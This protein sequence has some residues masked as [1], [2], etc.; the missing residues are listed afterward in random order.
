MDYIKLLREMCRQD[1]TFNEFLKTCEKDTYLDFRRAYDSYFTFEFE[2]KTVGVELYYGAT[3]AVIHISDEP[4]LV[5]IGFS[6]FKINHAE[7]E[8]NIYAEA[9]VNEVSQFFVP[10]HKLG[11]IYGHPIYEMVY[12][13]ADEELVTSDM[14]QKCSSEMSDEEISDAIDDDD[15]YIEN[16]FPFYYSEEEMSKLCDFLCELEINDL[17]SGN[18]GYLN[19]RIVLIDYS[20]YFP[21]YIF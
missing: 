1:E 4:T 6:D 13:D 10:C 16:L 11:K 5:K 9:C 15:C 8:A 3:K 7:R 12:V 20:G 2:N 14:W 17:H 21:S 19:G 18:I